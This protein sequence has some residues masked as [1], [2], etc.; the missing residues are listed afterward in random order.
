MLGGFYYVEYKTKGSKTLRYYNCEKT[1][2]AELD[3]KV[4]GDYQRLSREEYIR[5]R[6]EN[7]S[8]A[9][10]VHSKPVMELNTGLVFQNQKS[11]AKYFNITEAFVSAFLKGKSKS[12]RFN[13]KRMV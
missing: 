12:P 9:A 2:V 4:V 11:C 8:K 1:F 10:K 13:F 3:K 7:G 5:T 6:R